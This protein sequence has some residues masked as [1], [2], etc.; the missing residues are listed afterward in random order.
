MACAKPSDC[1]PCS[2]CPD[3]PAPVLPRCDVVLNDGVYANATVYIENGCIVLVQ[4]G[5]PLLYQPDINCAGAVGGGGGGGGLQGEQGPAGQA[6]TI[7]IGTVTSL[8]P[9]SAPT[10]VNVGTP[11]AAILN[12]GIPRGADGD[13]GA[14][15]GGATSSEGGIV[16]QQGAIQTPLPPSWP[17]V[18]E[19]VPNPVQGAGVSWAFTK[20]PANGV[21]LADLDIT[22]LITWFEN[23]LSVLADQNI[24]Q[25]TTIDDLVARVTALE[26]AP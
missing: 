4:Q 21:V 2:K 19:I 13:D 16:L 11:N 14:P 25:Q 18:L 10:V 23:E 9:G 8:P 3:S 17:P 12:I 1:A 24:A 7:Q 26:A 15:P 5:Q 20:N 6:A 22:G